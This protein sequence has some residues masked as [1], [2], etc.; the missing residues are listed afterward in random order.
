MVSDIQMRYNLRLTKADIIISPRTHSCDEAAPLLVF[1]SA[2]TALLH[3]AEMG[4]LLG[5]GMTGLS[6]KSSVFSSQDL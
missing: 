2:A 3:L 5:F 1:I 6:Y 4:M